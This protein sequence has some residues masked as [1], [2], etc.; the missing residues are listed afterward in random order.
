MASEGGGA[1][2][3]T[4]P[5]PSVDR[6]AMPRFLQTDTGTDGSVSAASLTTVAKAATRVVKIAD[7]KSGKNHIIVHMAEGER[8]AVMGIAEAWVCHGAVTALGFDILA[9]PTPTFVKVN[10]APN[11]S[12]LSFVVRKAGHYHALKGGGRDEFLGRVFASRGDDDGEG[13]GGFLRSAL[14]ALWSEHGFTDPNLL[15]S[16][17]AGACTVVFREYPACPPLD[18]IS[19][20]RAW[21]AKCHLGHSGNAPGIMHGFGLMLDGLKSENA[22]AGAERPLLS[23]P[24][25]WEATVNSIVGSSSNTPP[26]VLVCGAKNMG[27]STLARYLVNRLLSALRGDGVKEVAYI[28]TDLG[29]TEFT[30]PGFV[31]LVVLTLTEPM[32]GPALPFWRKPVL[33]HFIG[34]VTPR[35]CPSMYTTA[36]QNLVDAYRTKLR[37]S[38]YPL[39]CVINTHGWVKGLGQDLLQRIVDASRPQH[40]LQICGTTASKSFAVAPPP[41]VLYAP[42]Q[43]PAEEADAATANECR[44][45]ALNA[46]NGGQPGPGQGRSSPMVPGGGDAGGTRTSRALRE[47]QLCAYFSFSDP[48]AAGNGGPGRGTYVADIATSLA[49]RV[50]YKVSWNAVAVAFPGE[51]LG[52]GSVFQALNGSVVALGILDGVSLPG[53]LRTG[54]APGDQGQSEGSPKASPL[55]QL[56]SAPL[57]PSVGLGIVRS[58]DFQRQMFYIITPVEQKV[59]SRV[60]ILVRGSLN[61]PIKMLHWRLSPNH[62]P[63]ISFETIQPRARQLSNVRGVKRK[64]LSGGGKKKR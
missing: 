30:P 59:L 6:K 13:G 55:I 51:G 34:D 63:Y 32:L 48:D 8:L 20:A 18:K 39:P 54:G 22:Q 1:S 25:L 26:T 29:Q 37:T 15:V 41:P 28:D 50:P 27:K 5:P 53:V 56:R 49:H 47:E 31:S 52:D 45:H 58:I 42:Q 11:G 24:P 23:M 10:A 60:N 46:R 4:P 19:E 7:P 64:R 44:V 21:F 17:G 9:S 2:A 40:I 36:V 35:D 33:S 3:T 43:G 57:C 12:V 38:R 62:V 14:K 61:C 16:N